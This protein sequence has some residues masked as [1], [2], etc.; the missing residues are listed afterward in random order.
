[1]KTQND[2]AKSHHPAAQ[3]LAV[4]VSFRLPFSRMK[5]GSERD[6]IEIV[7]TKFAGD[8]PTA[9]AIRE[10]SMVMNKDGQWEFEP[11]PSERDES[12]L[13]RTRFDQ[14]EDAAA[15]VLRFHQDYP[16]A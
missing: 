13:A 1:M 4:P 16:E 7:A 5:N 6:R 11:S 12:F 15:C 8:R 9:W 3:L 14:C 10:S 2:H